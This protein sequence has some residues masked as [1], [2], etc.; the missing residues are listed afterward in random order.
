[1]TTIA[2]V[3]SR[4]RWSVRL[5]EGN[6]TRRT[7]KVAWMIKQ[8]SQA[9]TPAAMRSRRT[10]MRRMAWWCPAGVVA[11]DIVWPILRTRHA[12]RPDRTRLAAVVLIALDAAEQGLR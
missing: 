6:A 2:R 12:H 3:I 5:R 11:V 8:V 10:S 9:I 1:M 7:P 4:S